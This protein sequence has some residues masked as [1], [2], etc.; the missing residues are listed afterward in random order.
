MSVSYLLISVFGAIFQSPNW[1]RNVRRA[2]SKDLK[3]AGGS[4]LS[5]YRFLNVIRAYCGDVEHLVRGALAGF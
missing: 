1:N 5:P 2:P 4:I 3:S